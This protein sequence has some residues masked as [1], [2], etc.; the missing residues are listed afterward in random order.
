MWLTQR[1]PSDLAAFD[2]RDGRGVA[3]EERHAEVGAE[4]LRDASGP[5]PIAR[6]RATSVTY[7]APA[8]APG[9]IVFDDEQLRD[10]REHARSCAR[11]RF[12]VIAAPVGFCARGVTMSAVRRLRARGAARSG[13]SPSSSTGTGTGDER[14]RREQIE[15]RR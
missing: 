9:V 15:R 7:G 6:V 2:A 10:A 8:I 1:M 5:P 11:A 14:Q 12:G 13:S 3:G 4:R